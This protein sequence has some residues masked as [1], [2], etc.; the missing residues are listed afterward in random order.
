MLFQHLKTPLSSLLLAAETVIEEHKTNT[1]GLNSHS[2]L[3]SIPSL[4][5]FAVGA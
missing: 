4:P 2:V 1:L 3:P 5:I